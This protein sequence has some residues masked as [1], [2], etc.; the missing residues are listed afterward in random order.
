MHHIPLT[1][2][3]SAITYANTMAMFSHAANPP[4]GLAMWIKNR[5]RCRFA[6][7]AD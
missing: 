7:S 1:A 3:R 2:V 5:S 4:A 6:L